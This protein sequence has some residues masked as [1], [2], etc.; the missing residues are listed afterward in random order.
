MSARE[1]GASSARPDGS[2]P[3]WDLIWKNG[4]PAKV[5]IFAWKAGRE[6]L[7]TQAE[8]KRR[9]MILDHTCTLCGLGEESVHHALI[10]CPHAV[11][12]WDAMRENWEL[13][14]QEDLRDS[15]P[16]WIFRLLYKLPDVQRLASL[17][18]MWRIW[19]ARNEGTHQKPPVRSKAH[20]GSFQAILR[21]SLGSSSTQWRTW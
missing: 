10:R 16:E 12:L 5:R 3:V 4:A 20:A 11:A 2:R 7:A 14:T 15:E 6:A 1:T 8:K 13:P 21:R 17:M 18:I 19:Y 9:H